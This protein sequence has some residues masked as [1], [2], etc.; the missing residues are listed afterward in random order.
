M[1]GESLT[2]SMRVVT[3][4]F[5]L[6]ELNDTLRTSYIEY[7]PEIKMLFPMLHSDKCFGAEPKPLSC[8]KF[9]CKYGG[10]KCDRQTE[11]EIQWVHKGKKSEHAMNLKLTVI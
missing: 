9:L 1:S 8:F 6:L 4:N 11:D 3:T 7:C 10:L 5:I 2:L